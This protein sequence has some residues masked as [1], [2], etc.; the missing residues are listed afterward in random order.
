MLKNRFAILFLM[1]CLPFLAACST[2]K[3]R[4]SQQVMFKT[5]GVEGAVCD[6]KLGQ[7][8]L[9]YNVY[10]PQKIWVQKTKGPMYVSCRSNGNRVVEQTFGTL[11]ASSTYLNF[12]NAGLG[13]FYDAE[14]GASFKY[15]D[16]VIIDFAGTVAQDQPLPLYHTKG[17]LVP[18]EQGIEYMGPDTPALG[19]D[20]AVAERYRL[21][22]EEAAR[23]EAEEAAMEVERQRRIDSVEGGFNGDKGTPPATNDAKPT[24]EEVQISPLSEVK[25][26]KK[27]D[28]PQIPP[29]ASPKLGKPLF[30]SS[31]SF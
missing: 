2:M 15:P 19:Q 29:T 1:S 21:A 12:F 27:N 22:Y 23:L 18:S 11:I 20:K 10:P 3:E 6:V 7:N 8:K 9:R 24:S 14:S 4:A 5:E 28:A 25:S 31:T 26:P 16:E 13:I 30:Q 17:S